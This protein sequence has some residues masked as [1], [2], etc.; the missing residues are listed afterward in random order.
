MSYKNYK[1]IHTRTYLHTYIH[2]Y[3]YIQIPNLSS[4]IFISSLRL[5]FS[6]GGREGVRFSKDSSLPSNGYNPNK[7]G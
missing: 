5:S 1:Y 6:I 7:L 4:D 3:T 2:V